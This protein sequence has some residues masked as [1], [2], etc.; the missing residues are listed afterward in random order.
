MKQINLLLLL[1]LHVNISAQEP[2][3]ISWSDLASHIE[4]NDPFK[5]LSNEQLY[6]LRQ[7]A[8]YRE[9]EKYPENSFSTQEKSRRDSLE[10]LLISESINIDSLL[11]IRYKIADLRRKQAEQVNPALNKEKVK[12]S[13]Y[14]LPLNYVDNKVTEFLLVP[15]VGACIHTPPPPKNQLIYLTSKEGLEINSRFIAVTVEGILNTESKS[16]KL[17]LVDGTDDISSGYS[18]IE[19]AITTL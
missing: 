10:A 5:Q 2:K 16:S 1:V 18:I 15:W 19:G 12:I 8:N 6:N 17:F 13:G 3:V 14:L 7:V 9:I 4:F 11:A